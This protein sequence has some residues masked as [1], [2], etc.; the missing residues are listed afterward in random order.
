VTETFVERRRRLVRDEIGR[1]AIELFAARGFDA[2]TVDDIAEAAGTSQ[3]TFF[4][5]FATKDDIVLALARRLDE[6]LVDALDARPANE[7]AVAALREAYCA[8][9]HVEPAER[10][11]VLQVAKVLAE[12]P[13]LRA[14]AHGEYV[15]ENAEIVA[16]L[17][18][19]MGVPVD[20]RRV[21]VL[22]ATFAAVASVEFTTWAEAGGAGDPSEAIRSALALLED[23]LS[24]L[25]ATP[26]KGRSR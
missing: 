2:V 7:G 18:A 11:R 4:R 8:T 9:S 14:R 15:G 12:A 17:A 22:V 20:D 26:R 10:E 23:G 13:A 6:R 3:R 25:D 24:N 21:R 5:Y 1:V 19:R 16:R